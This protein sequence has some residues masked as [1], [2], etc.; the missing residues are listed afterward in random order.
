MV[1]MAGLTKRAVRPASGRQ[2]RN[3]PGMFAMRVR[4]RSSLA[5]SD[6]SAAFA[7]WTNPCNRSTS[8]A[9]ATEAAASSIRKVA[10]AVIA[11]GTDWKEGSP[12]SAVAKTTVRVAALS[13]S[14]TTAARSPRSSAVNTATEKSTIGP[15]LRTPACTRIDTPSP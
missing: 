1:W 8:T 13:A 9:T 5:R 3:A 2:R 12:E 11:R 15:P 6:A 7:C 14:A 4:K 10:P